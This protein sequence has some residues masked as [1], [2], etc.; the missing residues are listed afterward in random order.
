MTSSYEQAQIATNGV[1][2]HVT[3]TGPQ[4][5][6]LAIL[7]H[8]F[9]EF[10][11]GWRGQ[12]PSL[13][14]AGYR[15]WAP[16][17]RGYNLSDKPR[18]MVAYN[19]DMLAADVVG[20]V[21]ASGQERASLIGHDWGGAVAWW[22]AAKYPQRLE[23]LVVINCPHGAVLRRHLRRSLAQQRR[24]WYMFF[25]QVPWLP[26]VVLRRAN[27]RLLV[28]M[29]KE[30]G[31][32]QA[33]TATDLEL[34]RRAWSQPGA[35]TAMLNWYRAMLQVPPEPAPRRPI[36]VPT[37]LIWGQQDKFLGQDMAQPSIDLCSAGRL[38]FV[39]DATHWVHLEQPD[40]VNTMLKEFLLA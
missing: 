19:L 9:P 7:L 2:L 15:V 31:T 8:G 21:D 32:P 26:E 33:F 17:Q 25:F 28:R 40:R 30:S 5:G 14:A 4:R 27:W 1:H 6:P 3:Q 36:E 18:G 12:I 34:Y 23:R 22:V 16:D 35:V 20:L 37:L 11:Y 29:L 24:S 38:V 13:A 10:W 39:P